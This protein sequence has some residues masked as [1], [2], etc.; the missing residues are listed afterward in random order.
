MVVKP[1]SCSGKKRAKRSRPKGRYGQMRPLRYPPPPYR[2]S[3]SESK[4][5]RAVKC[6]VFASVFGKFVKYT[7]SFVKIST[8]FPAVRRE[9]YIGEGA[10]C[11]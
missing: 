8:I 10:F 9:R 2:Y 5:N 3:D 7:A 6:Y 11:S 4:E 1:F